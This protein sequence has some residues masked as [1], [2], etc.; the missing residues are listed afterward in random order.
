[1]ETLLQ[2]VRYGLRMLRKSPGFTAVALVVL[3][4]GIGANVAIFS[5]VNTVLLRP[6][7]YRDPG[8]LVMLWESLPGIGYGQVGTASGEYLDYRD[9]N[10]VFSGIAGYKNDTANLTGSGR[11]ERIHITEATANLFSVLG[12]QPIIGRTYTAEEDRP[13]AGKVAVLSYGLWKRRY[14]ADRNILGHAVDLDGQPYTVI[15]VMPASFQFPF[16]TLPYSE[17]AELWVP[18]AFTREE[19]ADRVREFGTFTVGR[20]KPGVSLQQAQEDVTRVAAEFQK[21]YPQ[22]YDGNIYVKPTASPLAA[23]IVGKVRPMLLVL[24]GAVGFVLLIACANLA[25]LLLARST[26]R[27]REMAV[28]AALGAS[29]GRLLRQFLTE[30]VLLA[31][32]GGALGLLAAFWLVRLLVAFGPEQVPRLHDVRID[33]AV[34]TFAVAISVITGILFGIAPAWRASR[35]ELQSALKEA[36]ARAGA[37][38]ER[39]R[40]RNGLVVLETACSLLLLVAAGLL[41]NSFIRVLR[42]PPGFNPS[43]VLIA[44]TQFDETRYPKA[45]FCGVAEKEIIARLR[46]LPGVHSVGFVTNL[47]LADPREI[48]FRIEGGPPNEFHNANNALVSEDY[49]QAIGIPLVRG[50]GLR[51]QDTVSTPL[52]AVINQTLARTYF[53]GTDPIGKRL[54]WGDRAPFTIVGVVG[55]VK[56]SALDADV[57]PMIYMSNFQVASGVSRHAVFVVRTAGDPSSLARAA[58]TTIW[59]VDKDL[60]VF[61]VSTMNDVLAASVAQRRFSMSLLSGFAVLALLMAAIGLYGVLSYSVSQRMHEMGLRMALGANARDLMRLVV[62]QG[63]RVVLT[64]IVAGLLASFAATRLLAGMLFE[65]SPLDPFTFATMAVVLVAAA[66]LASFVPARRAT[67]VDPMVAL[68]YE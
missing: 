28:R 8:R 31:A 62:G 10:R 23:D 22:I 24:L 53:S 41:L 43:G 17:Q 1:M 19:I 61:G 63:I 20:L 37:S 25:N 36:S 7:P 35:S 51:E 49:F 26:A 4:I 2:D 44:R 21:Q 13:G 3:T 30:S 57:A 68:R 29:Q 11:P 52:V 27:M 55:D 58:S 39:L 5:V 60:P 33:P 48:G 50:R 9:R 45:E 54:L 38:R 6:L 56:F 40:L 32:T 46:R 47:P 59:S 66:L 65:V 64:G 15:G 34:L 14:G 16:S 42:V 67:R 18:V 12:V